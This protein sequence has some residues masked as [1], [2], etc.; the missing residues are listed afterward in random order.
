MSPANNTSPTFNN[1]I[2]QVLLLLL[3]VGMAV[4]LMRE[5]YVFFPGFLGAVTVYILSRNWYRY[6]TKKKSWNKS[7]TALLFMLAFL[8]CVVLPIYLAVQLLFAKISGLFTNPQDVMDG[9]RSISAQLRAWTGQDLLSQER[10][11]EIQKV[12]ANLIPALLNSSATMLGNLFMILFLSFYMLTNGEFLEKKLSTKIA[13]R[14]ENIAIL[15]D[16]TNKMVKANALGIPLISLIQ[17]LV[18]MGGYWIFGLDD[19]VLFGFL[20]GIFAF[21]PIVGTALIWIP[22]VIYLFSSG[23]TG[24]GIGLAIYGAVVIGNIDYVARIS[25]LKTIGD[26]HPITTILGLIVGLQLFGFWGFIFGPLLISYFILL[27]KIYTS[28][29]GHMETQNESRE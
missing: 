29:F 21:F 9:L 26:V 8:L 27:F 5:L 10:I 16:E 22:L 7:L 24:A 15:A 6:L 17:G 12:G 2:R 18:A 25:F 14:K 23:E 3:V 13:L 28:E 4:L 20:T 1:R 19:F 11:Q